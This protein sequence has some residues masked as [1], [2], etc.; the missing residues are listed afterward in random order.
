MRTLRPKY[1]LIHTHQALWEAISTGTGR[2]LFSKAPILI[3]PASS[4]YYGE[5]AELARTKGFP[6]LRRLVLRNTFFAAISADIEGQWRNLGVPSDRIVRMSSGVNI[7]HFKP[8]PSAIERDMPKR[9]R[10]VF[11]G[12][13]HPQKNIDLLLALWPSVVERVPEATLLLIGQG[14]DRARLEDRARAIE[15]A[16]SI[17]FLGAVADPAEHLRRPTSSSCRVWPK[18]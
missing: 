3:Q 15:P 13:L 6:I 1:D 17:R 9:P 16:D 8:G 18:G 11:T 7:D 14:P 12:R 10:V 4:G 2:D 5:A